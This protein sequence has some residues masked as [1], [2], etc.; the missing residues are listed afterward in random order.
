MLSIEQGFKQ[1]NHL[2]WLSGRKLLGVHQRVV[3][4]LERYCIG[5]HL[6]LLN[7]CGVSQLKATDY[8]VY[9]LDSIL[10]W[11]KD[12]WEVRIDFCANSHH[13][14][15]G[16]TS[17]FPLLQSARKD[18][19][20]IWEERTFLDWHTVKRIGVY[21]R[22]PRTVDSEGRFC[23]CFYTAMDL[24]L[25]K[26]EPSLCTIDSWEDLKRKFKNQRRA[27]RDVEVEEM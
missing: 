27:L 26:L 23:G 1:Q 3:W 11:L 25:H 21:R 4:G 12:G 6:C 7:G 5:T 2:S 10:G 19:Y 15:K 18:G 14:W 16:N 9:M 17:E 22:I 20:R 13:P 24:F 8:W